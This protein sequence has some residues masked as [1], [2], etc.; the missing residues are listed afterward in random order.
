MGK[1]ARTWLI[2]TDPSTL[3]SIYRKKYFITNTAV[4]F[5]SW[6]LELS[7]EKKTLAIA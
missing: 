3:A 6:P 5:S 4:F 1:L 7:R 2:Q